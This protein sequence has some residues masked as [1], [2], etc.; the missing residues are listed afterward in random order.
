[1]AQ[2]YAPLASYEGDEFS[3]FLLTRA[4]RAGGWVAAHQTRYVQ[5]GRVQLD[6]GRYA[7]HGADDALQDAPREAHLPLRRALGR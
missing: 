6:V 5:G 2:A 3:V 1:L 4:R 7:R